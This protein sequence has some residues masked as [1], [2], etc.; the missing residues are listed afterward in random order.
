MPIGDSRGPADGP[1]G[2]AGLATVPDTALVGVGWDHP[3]CRAPLDASVARYAAVAPDVAVTWRYRS[4]YEFGEGR[5]DRLFGA[6][7]LVIFDHPFVGEAA[8]HGYLLDL[9]PF[10]SDGDRAAMAADSVGASLPSY[11]AEGGLYGLPID[12]AAQVAAVRPDL[13]DRLDRPLPRTF[14]EVLALADAARTRGLHVAAPAKPT[15]A[16]CMMITLAAN[17]GHPPAREAEGFLDPAVGAEALERLRALVARLHPASARWNPIACL[18]HMT[19]GDEI[20]YVPYTFGYTSYS[21]PGVARAVRFHDIVAAGEHGP[22]GSLLGGAGVGVLASTAAPKAAVAYA[23]WLCAP[24]SQR[25]WYVDAGGQPA[26]RSAWTDPRCDAVTGG[27][28]SNTLATH[29]MAYVRP[30]VPG[31]LPFFRAATEVVHAC[32]FDGTPAPAEAARR[33]DA[34]YRD[35]VRS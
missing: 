31:F 11:R 23:R 26:S 32:L 10:L 7:D 22:A 18:D 9:A 34:L 13:L 2:Q 33:V 29:D 20:V 1:A 19:G 21:R 28:F 6:G 8:R 4:L 24:E 3:R 35:H 27:F 25:S 30:T 16:L 17:T 5:L 12:A 15:D 14:D